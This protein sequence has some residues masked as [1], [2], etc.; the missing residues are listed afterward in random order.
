MRFIIYK[1]ENEQIIFERDAP[2][3]ATWESMVDS[4]PVDEPRYI[5]FDLEYK[6]SD[7]RATSKL[8]FITWYIYTLC[9]FNSLGLQI[10]LILRRRF[11]I[12][13]LRILF[14]ESY[15]AVRLMMLLIW[16]ICKKMK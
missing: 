9:E 8:L 16:M 6:E 14:S 7:G 5:S 4:L 11:Y 1:I 3:D 12:H 2:R 13:L 15:Q 10:M